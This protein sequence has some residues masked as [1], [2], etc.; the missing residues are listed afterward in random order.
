MHSHIL[1]R[2]HNVV[3]TAASFR[4]VLP[5][6]AQVPQKGE[7][8]DGA[9]EEGQERLQGTGAQLVAPWRGEVPH[10][11]GEAFPRP[12]DV[13]KQVRGQHADQSGDGQRQPLGGTRS[14]DRKSVV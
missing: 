3:W 4:D 8:Q 7:K 5:R 10:H 6:G 9:E 11:E 13:G 1:F 12:G 2:Y 14:L